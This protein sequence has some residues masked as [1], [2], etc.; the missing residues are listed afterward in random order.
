LVSKKWNL[1]QTKLQD[2]GVGGKYDEKLDDEGIP[3]NAPIDYE[4]ETGMNDTKIKKQNIALP[5]SKERL[6]VTKHISDYEPLP[7]SHNASE[8]FTKNIN[9]APKRVFP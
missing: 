6:Y 2:L 1:Y 9:E 4:F 3:T 8:K 5:L 7:V